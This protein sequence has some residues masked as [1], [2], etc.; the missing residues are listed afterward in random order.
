MIGDDAV[1]G[2]PRYRL[3][4]DGFQGT[5]FYRAGDDD[6][7]EWKPILPNEDEEADALDNERVCS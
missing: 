6:D 2:R 4:G 7:A 5:A 1:C 3:M